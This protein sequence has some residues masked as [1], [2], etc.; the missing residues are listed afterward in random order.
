MSN[1]KGELKIGD[2]AQRAGVNTST[3]RYY[4]S[5]GLLPAP[6]RING[7]RR[8]STDALQM[9][10]MIGFAQKAGFTLSEIKTLFQDF[11]PNTPAGER[12]RTLANQKLLEID[13]LIQRAQQMKELLEVGMQCGCLRLEDCRIVNQQLECV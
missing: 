2:I 5:M 10:H 9:L 13:A 11:D 3:I 8:Y 6:K 12:W 1:S 7:H 4:E